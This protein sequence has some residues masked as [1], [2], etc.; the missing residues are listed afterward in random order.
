MATTKTKPLSFADVIAAEEATVTNT[1]PALTEEAE[2]AHALIE[3][4]KEQAAEAEGRLNG[5]RRKLGT[6]SVDFTPA[7][8]AEAFHGVEYARLLAEGQAK[9]AKH[10][11]ES[12]PNGDKRLAVLVAE[13]IERVMPYAAEVIPSFIR[14]AEA[15]ENLSTGPVIVVTQDGKATEKG[16]VL[17]AGVTIRSFRLPHFQQIDKRDVEREFE[18]R[19]WFVPGDRIY[20]NAERQDGFMVDVIKVQELR[21]YA[22]TPT[23]ANDPND[24]AVSSVVSS[25][26][27][28]IV[29]A[30]PVQGEM[31]GG[32][33]VQP[34]GGMRNHI[35]GA[36]VRTKRFKVTKNGDD[37]RVTIEA[38]YELEGFTPNVTDGALLDAALKGTK[39][40]PDRFFA[41]VGVVDK[42]STFETR[43]P[44]LRVI[45][46]RVEL[47]SKT[48]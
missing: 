22:S 13:A 23:I 47:V 29:R 37:R 20:Q 42:V 25:L 12:L 16:G 45:G 43:S 31:T 38:E 19:G 9:T 2:K 41:G 6:G 30:F 39:P 10:L 35:M 8:Y 27:A 24:L 32:L 3:E 18:A 4:R 21:A 48:A 33:S 44:D 17:G 15:P 5:Y 46:V 34:G 40:L 14:P 36:D 7:D 11:A 26:S 1:L 28:E